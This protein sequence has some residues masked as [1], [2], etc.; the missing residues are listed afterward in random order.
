MN[1]TWKPIVAGVIDII[2]GAFQLLGALHFGIV[3]LFVVGLSNIVEN[4]SMGLFIITLPL[5]AFLAIIGGINNM[6]RTKWRLAMA[7]SIAAS[8]LHV[9]GTV[10]FASNPPYLLIFTLP[11]II[12]IVMTLISK[13]EFE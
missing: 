2:S 9:P 7:G 1:K 3:F 10:I 8:L 5:T 11:G 13:K 6:R 4:W 12:A